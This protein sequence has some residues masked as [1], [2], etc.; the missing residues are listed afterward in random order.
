MRQQRSSSG[1]C[2]SSSASTTSPIP[3]D[4][5]EAGYE[6]DSG[7]QTTSRRQQVRRIRA[8]SRRASGHVH[9][10]FEHVEPIVEIPTPLTAK[11]LAYTN[12]PI[13]AHCEHL[14]PGNAEEAL[15]TPSTTSS[16]SEI[17]TPLDELGLECVVEDAQLVTAHLV[18]ELERRSQPDPPASPD[19]HA[20]IYL[21]DHVR[22]LGFRDLPPTPDLRPWL[23]VASGEPSP[24]VLASPAALRV[25]GGPRPRLVRMG[26]HR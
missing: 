5:V 7:T 21:D 6:A 8:R 25:I 24:M 10:L 4:D 17:L 9:S 23:A 13:P 14:L 3:E 12:I 26:N 19:P 18:T 22:V 16:T 1:S 11:E 15:G 2:R 20:D